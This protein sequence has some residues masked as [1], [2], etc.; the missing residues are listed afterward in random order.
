MIV[1]K[2]FPSHRVWWKQNSS[3]RIYRIK[4]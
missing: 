1:I 2:L 3:V 4:V